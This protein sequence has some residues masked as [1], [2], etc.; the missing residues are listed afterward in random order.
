MFSKL[1]SE[2]YNLGKYRKSNTKWAR[3]NCPFCSKKD[4]SISLNVET[5][6]CKCHR[7]LNY[8]YINDLKDVEEQIIDEV[9]DG[10]LPYGV[11]DIS[12]C[13]PWNKKLCLEYLFNRG[14]THED[15]VK[16]NIKYAE[17]GYLEGRIFIPFFLKGKLVYYIAR[18]IYDESKEPKKILNPKGRKEL[19]NIERASQYQEVVL[20]EGVFDA[21]LTGDDAIPILGKSLTQYQIDLMVQHDITVVNIMLDPEVELHYSINLAKK[22]NKY[23]RTVNIIKIP[24]ELGDPAEQQLR[25]RSNPY[26][27]KGLFKEFEYNMFNLT[28]NLKIR[29]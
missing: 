23:F 22:I 13:Y 28:K 26:G 2:Q 21:I 1:I 17:S 29:W 3:L 16:Y 14:I 25:L 7:C 10:E 8:G 18:T 24:K 5:G 20:V 27:W 4:Y 11:C 6:Y 15:V 19:F 12:Q 9:F